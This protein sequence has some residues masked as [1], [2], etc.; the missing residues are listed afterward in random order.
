MVDEEDLRAFCAHEHPRLVRALSL[1]CRDVAVAEEL[2]Q[3]ALVRACE[4]WSDVGDMASP[5]AWVQRVAVN[6]S[7]SWYRRRQAERRARARHGA[8][9]DTHVDP[10]L[11]DA[12]AVRAAIAGLPAAQRSVLALRFYLNLS[13]AETAAVLGCSPG[14][15]KQHSSRAIAALRGRFAASSSPSPPTPEAG[16]AAGKERHHDG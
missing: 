3:E 15:V 9:L 2:A 12:L 4:R 13:V 7:R 1:Q 8:V 10:D 14:A 5:G 6:L 16:T 11:A